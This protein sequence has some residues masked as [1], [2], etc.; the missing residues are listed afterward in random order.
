MSATWGRATLGLPTGTITEGSSAQM[1]PGRVYR[2][3]CEVTGART[4]I[5][6]WEQD[7]I[8]QTYNDIVA[9]GATPTYINIDTVQYGQFDVRGNVTIEFTY[10]TASPTAMIA[11]IIWAIAI[12][13][14]LVLAIWLII[15]L[16]GAVQEIAPLLP[17]GE[18]TAW[19]MIG[20]AV[21][22]AYLLVQQIRGGGDDAPIVVIG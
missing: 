22:G 20:A 5:P 6:G 19:L 13:I 16:N 11:P 12:G 8:N 10:D 7:A 9:K 14:T 3:T 21:V 17:G 15:T 18:T 2:M 4:L 1:V